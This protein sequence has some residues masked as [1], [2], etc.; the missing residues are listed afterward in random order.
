MEIQRQCEFAISHYNDLNDALAEANGYDVF[1]SL[2]SFLV[3]AANIS[4]IFFPS[5]SKYN[6]RGQYL[7]NLL[8]INGNSELA[9]RD[10]RNFFEHFDEKLDEWH[11]QSSRYRFA[12]MNIGPVD[13]DPSSA[14]IDHL[15]FFNS[16]T[17][18]FI[19]LGR[20]YKIIPLYTEIKDLLARVN[21]ELN[22]LMT[23]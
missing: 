5:R 21:S 18:T 1:R 9:K 2:Q 22:K 17:Y 19:F 12:D 11:A 3:N 10:A 15:R 4:K 20:R 14:P 8:S 6:T 7:R 13:P 23:V 16:T